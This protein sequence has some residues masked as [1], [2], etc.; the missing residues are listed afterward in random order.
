M[1]FENRLFNYKNP[2][3][4]GETIEQMLRALVHKVPPDVT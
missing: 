3:V 4:D 1:G 2:V